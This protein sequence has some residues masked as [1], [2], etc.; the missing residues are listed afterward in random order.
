VIG[1][2]FVHGIASR[3][4]AGIA[5][6]AERETQY[7]RLSAQSAPSAQSASSFPTPAARARNSSEDP[8]A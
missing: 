4:L 5:A 1:P 3:T 2:I 8:D 6:A 7:N